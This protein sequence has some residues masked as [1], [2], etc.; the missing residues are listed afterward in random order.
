MDKSILDS[1]EEKSKLDVEFSK[2]ASKAN[3]NVAEWHK[4]LEKIHELPPLTEGIW[5]FE[6]LVE[7]FEVLANMSHEVTINCLEL[8]KIYQEYLDLFEKCDITDMKI[9]F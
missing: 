3:S 6:E 4:Q 8:K 2:I 5:V 9:G 7:G 1:R